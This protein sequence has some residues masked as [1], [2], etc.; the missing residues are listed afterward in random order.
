LR[1]LGFGVIAIIGMS[2]NETQARDIVVK[3]MCNGFCTRAQVWVK[4]QDGTRGWVSS[5]RFQKQII[6]PPTLCRVSTHK[7][8]R[9]KQVS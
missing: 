8:K 7:L 1:Q 2:P 3:L 5:A 4:M 9:Q 6:L